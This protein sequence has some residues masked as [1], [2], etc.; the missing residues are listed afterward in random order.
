MDIYHL[1]RALEL[2]LKRLR[3]DAAIL[4]AN[5][6][7]IFGFLDYLQAGRGLSVSRRLRY[8]ASL[9]WLGARVG[10]PFSDCDRADIQA[11]VLRI[12]DAKNARTGKPRME[13][14]KGQDIRTL[15]VFFRWLRGCEDDEYPPE[16]K[17]LRVRQ[18]SRRIL[19]E[20]LI[21]A[22]EYSRALAA[23]ENPRDRALL[24][25]LW[26]GGLRIG[27]ALNLK[28]RNVLFDDFGAQLEVCGKTG[29]RRVRLG[30]TP[31]LIKRWLETHPCRDDRNALLFVA[32][33][34]RGR[35]G[36]GL[37]YNAASVTIK[38]LFVRAG[39]NN[40]RIHAH[41]FRHSKATEFER[42]GISGAKAR[43]F[44]GWKTNDM[45]EVYS[46]L[47]NTDIDD[48]VIEL[49]KKQGIIEAAQ[50]HDADL[51][52]LLDAVFSDAKVRK[53]AVRAI[54]EKGKGGLLERLA[55]PTMPQPCVISTNYPMSQG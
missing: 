53:E 27:E 25:I 44:F 38:R 48:A 5:R 17:W 3:D 12:E 4:P 36:E 8:A 16:V 45:S 40:K 14:T 47:A 29:S 10:K 11:L 37:R 20:D 35:A 30:K 49:Y 50:A 1:D 23:C 19:P 21:A 7:A 54:K 43:G 6:D 46:H 52:E 55:L 22:D 41:L 26:E 24:G 9:A 31:E 39:I 28:I 34:E 51:N 33:G 13:G 15:K 32:G 18:K 42:Q 2:A